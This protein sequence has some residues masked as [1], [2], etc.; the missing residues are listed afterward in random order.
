MMH[1]KYSEVERTDQVTSAITVNKCSSFTMFNFYSAFKNVN[2]TNVFIYHTW[3]PYI[4]MVS[5]STLP[6]NSSQTHL[7]PP[8]PSQPHASFSFLNIVH[9]VQFV[10]P[11]HSWVWGHH[12]NVVGLPGT[13]P[14]R[15]TGSPFPSNC[16]QLP[17]EVWEILSP[18]LLHRANLYLFS[19]ASKGGF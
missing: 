13:T 16:Q 12:W 1:F 9:W 15:K 2:F 6:P 14:L 7:P 3:I 18:L 4:F 8:T 10:L 5:T 17:S 11:I 19:R